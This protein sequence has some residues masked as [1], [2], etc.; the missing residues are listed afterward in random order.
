MIIDYE[1]VRKD[2]LPYDFVRNN[3]VIVTKSD[4]KY[5]IISTKNPSKQIYEELQRHLCSSF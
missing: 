3:E 1:N 2:L 4:G 5:L